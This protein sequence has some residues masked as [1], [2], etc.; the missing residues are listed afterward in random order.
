MDNYIHQISI[1]YNDAMT[2]MVCG[3]CGTITRP[4]KPI[5]LFITKERHG[6]K[7][8]WAVCPEC[9]KKHAYLLHRLLEDYYTKIIG[10]IDVLTR[11]KFCQSLGLHVRYLDFIPTNSR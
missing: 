4:D 6:E 2:S 7:E 3:I 1:R 10:D 11:D 5:D 9:G 8:E